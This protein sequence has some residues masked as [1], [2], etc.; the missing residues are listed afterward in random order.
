MNK[1]T[2][3]I[4]GA[5]V[6]CLLVLTVGC[7]SR[8]V[9]AAR[10]SSRLIQDADQAAVFAAARTALT[11]RFRI[12]KADPKQGLL[13][14]QPLETLATEAAGRIG[15]VVGAKRR[16]RRVAEVQI[17]PQGND[18]RVWCNVVIQHYDTEEVRSFSR[19]HGIADMPTETPIDTDAGTTTE[20][21]VVWTDKGRDRHMEREIL[22]ALADVLSSP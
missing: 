11:E 12:E 21:N 17:K 19:D 7:T 13:V 15:D 4:A 16:V 10:Y 2:L 1:R 14:S 18:I 3:L 22:T 6:C 5:N 9:D 20:Q 8:Q